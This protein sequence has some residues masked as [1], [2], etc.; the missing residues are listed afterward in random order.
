MTQ[1][2]I[3]MTYLWPDCSGTGGKY[4][5]CQLGLKDLLCFS[6]SICYLSTGLHKTTTIPFSFWIISTGTPMQMVDGASK[7]GVPP[8][9]SQ[10]HPHHNFWTAMHWFMSKTGFYHFCASIVQQE[11]CNHQVGRGDYLGFSSLRRS[12]NL[13]VLHLY[14]H[15][16][17][18]IC[19]FHQFVLIGTE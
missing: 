2:K 8:T 1:Y 11:R 10:A 14:R 6:N 18:L 15:R 17:I 9:D 16:Q 19:W 5:P 13:Q 3:L 4:Y 7:R 12:G